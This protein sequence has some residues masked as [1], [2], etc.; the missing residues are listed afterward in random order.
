MI[1]VQQI[2]DDL[3][4]M[5]DEGYQRF[6]SKLIPN[7]DAQLIIGVRTPELRRYS[8]QL[9]GTPAADEFLSALPHKYYEENNLHAFLLERIRDYDSLIDAIDAFLPY[10]DNWATCDGM[11]PKIL[12][13]HRHRLIGRIREWLC[14]EHPYTIRF[15]LEM[16]MLHYLE[17]DFD[18]EY[19][20]LAAGIMHEDYYV[21]MMVAWYFA[22]ALAFQYDA[23]IPYLENRV[24]SDWIHHKT[25]QKATESY[26]ITPE[27]KAYLRTLRYE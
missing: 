1:C 15:G 6:Q 25:I 10:I 11:R 23:V 27:Q 4:G 13:E 22:T 5:K 12:K 7:I 14:S 3:F 16:L 18:P 24:L 17:Q 26:R 2:R 9:Y 8:R 21:R 20:A 19:P